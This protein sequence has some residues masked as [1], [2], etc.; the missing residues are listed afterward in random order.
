MI[1][2]TDISFNTRIFE[3]RNAFF[4]GLCFFF[5]SN[6]QAD[7]DKLDEEQI[8]EHRRPFNIASATTT[9]ATGSPAVASTGISVAHG[10][11]G[12]TTLTAKNVLLG[13]GTDP[14]GFAAPGNTGIPLVSAGSATNPA[15]GTALVIGGGTGLTTTT[16]YAVLCGG[17]NTTAPLQS[18]ASVGSA[19]AIL[20][21]GGAGALP[22]FQTLSVN[23]QVFTTAGAGTY[24]PT[25]GMKFCVVEAVAGGGGSGG[26]GATTVVQSAGGGSGSYSRKVLTAGQ[27]GAAIAYTV[28]AGGAAGVTNGA[29]GNGTATTLGATLV[30]TNFGTGSAIG[31]TALAAGGAGGALGTGGVF[32]GWTGASSVTGAA[33]SGANAPAGFGQGGQAT[34]T[35]TGSIAG[36]NGQGF[37]SGAAGASAGAITPAVAIG[38]TGAGGAIVITEYI[39]A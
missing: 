5:A 17:T 16:A 39:L 34:Y 13:E 30:T 22:T 19:G 11:S 7:Q 6:V 26:V 31:T 21:S 33:G 37:G 32:A 15:F 4:I 36:I 18:I 8:A 10:G 24:T 38:G 27:I 35:N 9:N 14:I 25:S 20:T 28:G 3:K 1:K 23:V 2:N 12:L 29:G